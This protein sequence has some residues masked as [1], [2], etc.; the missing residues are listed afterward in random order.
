MKKIIL[1]ALFVL[2]LFLFP[3]GVEAQ[4]TVDNTITCNGTA[5][6]QL[7]APAFGT[8][9]HTYLW[10]TGATTQT[11]G[12]LIAGNYSV[13]VTDAS[14]VSIVYTESLVDP[15]LLTA[16]VVTTNVSCNAGSNGTAIAS[17]NGGT[18][19][20]T[21]LWSTGDVTPNVINL[22]AGTH[23]V[24]VTDI[25][26]CTVIDNILI[27]EPPL[28]ITVIA[29]GTDVLCFGDNTGAASVLAFGGTGI[30]NYSWSTG[31]VTSAVSNLLAGN[32]QVTVS[33]ANGCI[34]IQTI[35]I[36]EPALPVSIVTSL[37]DVSCNGGNDGTATATASGGTGALT[38][39]WSTGEVT[40]TISNLVAGTY[41]VTVTDGNAC[42]EITSVIVGEPL[43][44]LQVSINSTNINCFGLSDGTATAIGSGG[45]GGFTYLWSTGDALANIV[46]LSAGTYDVTVTDMNGCTASSSIDI[47][48]PALPIHIHTTVLSNVTCNSGSDGAIS[49]T[50]DGGTG[51][52][53]YSWSTGS[54]LQTLN[55]IVAGTYDVTVTDINGCFETASI[56]VSEPLAI[57]VVPT[58]TPS[59]CD[60]H[61][62]GA[63]NLVVSGGTGAYDFLWTEINFDSTYVSQNLINVRGGTYALQVT[64]ASSCVYLDTFIIS[65]NV[66]V[67][68]N[69]VN[70]TY[71]C[72]GSTGSVGITALGAGVGIYYDYEWSSAYTNGSFI[73]NDTVFVATPSFVAGNYSITV[74]DPNGCMFYYDSV[75][76]QSAS[77]LVVSENITHNLCY[78]DSVGVIQLSPSGGDPQPGYHVTWSG[79]SGFISTA[80]TINNLFVGDYTYTVIDDGVC[81]IT[82][83]IRIEPIDPIQGSIVAQNITC[84]SYSDG[85]LQAI[86]SGGTGFL[87][88][89]WS[90]GETTSFVDSLSLGS[91]YLTVTDS[92][93]CFYLDSAMLIEPN[94]ISVI[95]DSTQDVSCFGYDDGAIWITTAGGVGVLNYTWLHEGLL[96]SEIT[97]DI[98]DIY[99]G[100]YSVNVYDS[101]GCSAVQNFV[102]NQPIET[103]FLDSIYAISCNNGSN[104]YWELTPTGPYNPYV[105]IFSTGDTMSTDTIVSPYISGLS[106]GSYSVNIVDVNGCVWDYEINFEQ[107]LPMTVGTVDIVPVVCKGANTGSVGMD[108]IYGG[109]SPYTYLWDNG[110]TTNPI[111]NI[112]AE[113]YNVTITDANG[114]IIYETYEVEEPYEWIKYFPE[115]RSTSCRQSEDGQII[116]YDED[117]YSSPFNNMFYL[118]DS[119]GV[120]I[121]SVYTGESIGNLSS[122]NYVTILVNEYGCSATDSIYI[123]SAEE[124][125]ILIPNLVTMNADGYNDVFTVKGGCEYQSFL[126]KIFTDN[127]VQIFESFECDF[128]WDPHDNN[129]VANS[130]YYYY[131]KVEENGKLY[132]F[133][134]S[135]N[136]TK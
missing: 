18:G 13:T 24:T 53:I 38:Y 112:P 126:V 11:I 21:Y 60:G 54:S 115:V 127:G 47:T 132:E 88:Y 41:D 89:S 103:I 95:I 12:S 2:G 59:S 27:T 73:T 134:S 45:S 29:S 25:N 67:D 113:M 52:L 117:V 107:P 64:D 50:A 16:S 104:G 106:S 100:N 97:E 39:L 56:A 15:P 124:D 119:L 32:Y 108:A 96:Y 102:I 61:N 40:P 105:A 90:S 8:A 46:N 86:Y 43:L 129:A 116:L 10:N 87:D 62:D 49:A 42:T 31:D 58:I 4:I 9:P 110:M 79:P 6:G 85:S 17:G 136:I 72:N 120:L 76:N 71:V 33:D 81:T 92:V 125:C 121:D 75:M 99:A 26:G 70:T 19:A 78:G 74:T 118:Y 101:I 1:L 69:I 114:C 111:I 123:G 7:T 91:Y 84:N 20:Y 14:P 48:E 130:V 22:I 63:I 128:V 135:I 44:P 122:G 98:V 94:A 93:G 109:T 82:S 83:T 23:T 37:T 28:A 65:N 77:P 51:T 68:V 57:V 34:Q 80:F 5:T 131:I 55:A 35:A 30:L 3:Q 66:I 36:V 133:K